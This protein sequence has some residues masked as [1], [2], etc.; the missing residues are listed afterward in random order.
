MIYRILLQFIDM[1]K[2]VT[3]LLLCLALAQSS[4][5][6]FYPDSSQ[7]PKRDS[8]LAVAKTPVRAIQVLDVYRWGH[9]HKDDEKRNSAG[10]GDII[11]I[12]VSGLKSLLARANCLD[13]AGKANGT[14]RKQEIR[15]FLDGRMIKNIAP[16]SGAPQEDEGELQFHLQRHAENDEIWADL[17]GAPRR[18]QFFLRPTRVSIGLENEYAIA[19]L[20]EHFNLTRIRKG[21][22]WFCVVGSFIYLVGLLYLAKKTNLL[23]DRGIDAS[24]IGIPYANTH[25]HFSLSRFQMAFWFSLVIASFV[26]IWLITGAFDILTPGVLALIGISAGT[27]L[28]AIVIDTSKGEDIIKQTIPLQQEESTLQQDILALQTQ[29]I[30]TGLAEKQTRLKQVQAE[31]VKNKKALSQ[32]SEGFFNDLLSDANGVSFHRLQMF[33]WTIV[34]GMLFFYSVWVRLAMPEFSATLLALQGITAGTY[35]GFKI[36][37]KQ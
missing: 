19:S 17:L 32:K 3:L 4:L 8:L 15:L 24:A 30:Q 29:Q 22:F 26:F 7:I 31:I 14:C 2:N 21:W 35:L 11:V 34:L 33:V 18:G 12:K 5:G 37:E 16:E 23:R 20:V 13:S 25:L 36:P 10:I 1:A 28:S 27:S 6:Y 9:P